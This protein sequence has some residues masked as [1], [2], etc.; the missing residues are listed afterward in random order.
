M[1][2]VTKAD[3]LQVGANLHL[4]HTPGCPHQCIGTILCLLAG[5]AK[6]PEVAR[7]EPVSSLAELFRHYSHW[8]RGA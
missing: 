7:E 5:E 3:G 8:E 1:E 2:E 6:T 4:A